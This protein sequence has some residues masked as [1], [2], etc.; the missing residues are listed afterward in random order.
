MLQFKEEMIAADTDAKLF[1]VLM[2]ISNAR[3]DRHL[4]VGLVDGGLDL[5]DIEIKHAPIRFAVDYGALDVYSFFVSDYAENILEYTGENQPEIGDK[6]I[7]VN[8]QPI[9][10]Y[11]DTVEPYHRYSTIN[12][13]WWKFAE[14]LPQQTY[15]VSS[16]LQKNTLE[17]TLE[18]KDGVQYSIELPYFD[19]GS[20]EWQGFYQ[21][22]GDRRY[23]GFSKVYS[24]QTYVLFKHDDGQK[25]LVLDWYGFRENL[26]ADMDRL[27][28]YAAEY[29]MLDY[30]IIWDG[31]RSRG[32]SK[33]ASGDDYVRMTCVKSWD[34]LHLGLTRIRQGI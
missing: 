7:T 4:S 11:F 33:G 5:S 18:K 12:G 27:V 20:I 26:V 28:E 29:N 21:G 15:R 3:K 10:E 23:P 2:K 6:L 14:A 31:T 24:C 19:P 22:F 16:T 13:L 32:G 34:D 9:D 30:A 8:G 25:V 17:C 1:N